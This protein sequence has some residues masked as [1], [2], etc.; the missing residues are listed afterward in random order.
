MKSK[1]NKTDREYLLKNQDG[2]VIVIVLFVMVLIT[3]IGLAALNSTDTELKVAQT[4]RCFKQN[5]FQAD[6]AALAAEEGETGEGDE[7]KKS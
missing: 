5:L 2:S 3:I 7:K 1:K 6:A 4:D